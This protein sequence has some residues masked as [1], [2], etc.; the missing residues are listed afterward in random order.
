MNLN[1]EERYKLTYFLS[2]LNIIFS[3]QKKINSPKVRMVSQVCFPFHAPDWKQTPDTIYH[4][5]EDLHFTSSLKYAV[6]Q[7]SETQRTSFS[8]Q[9]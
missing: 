8:S 3:P 4:K 6:V 5:K 1:I 7:I 2:P 9:T